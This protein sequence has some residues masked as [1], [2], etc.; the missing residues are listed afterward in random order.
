MFPFSLRFPQLLSS[1]WA[2][3]NVELAPVRHRTIILQTQVRST[4][5]YAPTDFYSSSMSKGDSFQKLA[6]A[7]ATLPEAWCPQTRALATPFC[8]LLVIP[9]SQ[10]KTRFRILCFVN[11]QKSKS[12]ER[13]IKELGMA[14]WEKNKYRNWLHVPEA[15]IN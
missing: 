12:S 2:L 6:Q 1:L 15:K 13:L 3:L 7:Q 4:G 8:R 5:P 14:S 9:H 11:T 10:Q